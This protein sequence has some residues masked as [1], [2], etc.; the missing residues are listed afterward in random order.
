M[1]CRCA[2]IHLLKTLR[3]TVNRSRVLLGF[4]SPVVS[5]NHSIVLSFPQRCTL[6]FIS[7]KLI[8]ASSQPPLYFSVVAELLK[9]TWDDPD[10]K[11]FCPTVRSYASESV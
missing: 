3:A 8:S 4:S 9:S 6:C 2:Q 10:L 11:Y 1:M 7:C 5:E